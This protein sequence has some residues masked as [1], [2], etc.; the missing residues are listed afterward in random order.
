MNTPST[1]NLP[2]QIHTSSTEQPPPIPVWSEEAMQKAETQIPQQEISNRLTEQFQEIL[3]KD[4]QNKATT[5]QP[6]ALEKQNKT[7][8]SPTSKTIKST[9]QNVVSRLMDL[10]N[11][12]NV[13][14]ETSTTSNRSIIPER[15]TEKGIERARQIFEK[16]VN[17]NET[18]F[19]MTIAELKE[20]SDALQ[21][22]DDDREA[23]AS[24][25]GTDDLF[26]ERA[27]ISCTTE[28]LKLA[29]KSRKQL[30]N[31]AT[32]QQILGAYHPLQQKSAPQTLASPQFTQP[33]QELA[34]AVKKMNPE[35]LSTVGT[36]EQ[37][38]RENNSELMN[39]YFDTLDEN[40]ISILKQQRDEDGQNVFHKAVEEI[41]D[42]TAFE[43]IIQ[44]LGSELIS[45]TDSIG[46]TPLKY[47]IDK[48]N[49]ETVSVLLKHIDP[50]T[51]AKSNIEGESILDF[52]IE[53][54]LDSSQQLAKQGDTSTVK[55]ELE[56][57]IQNRS[58]LIQLVIEKMPENALHRSS[59]FKTI[60][61]LDLDDLTKT[62][63]MS[64][65]SKRLGINRTDS[66]EKELERIQTVNDPIILV[67]IE[68]P[69]ALNYLMGSQN[70]DEQEGREK[71]ALAI[72]EKSPKEFLQNTR[73]PIGNV[74]HLIADTGNWRLIDEVIN[75]QGL[76]CAGLLYQQ[77]H[78]NQTPIHMAVR[79][80]YREQEKYL[81]E[82]GT[83]LSK[84]L[85]DE[86]LEK[87]RQA[88]LNN[89][90]NTVRD[91]CQNNKKIPLARISTLM[92]KRLH[93]MKE[94][95][96]CIGKMV[97]IMGL[98]NYSTL[99]SADT[100]G[101]TCEELVLSMDQF[102]S[103]LKNNRISE[104]LEAIKEKKKSGY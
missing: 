7:P 54:L 58:A 80:A 18:S 71:V 103:A 9:D 59:L 29:L 60:A 94:S 57:N 99:Q 27:T 44:K 13:E 78:L 36:F 82:M 68:L 39:L 50:D 42:Q 16:A 2:P 30:Y 66:P 55:R 81:E 28:Q 90:W 32:A 40:S 63:L 1:T 21:F 53:D 35:E 4:E 75:R 52:A 98:T 46:N 83:L 56:E 64:A 6:T 74:L 91:L 77:T 88:V 102:Y 8:S 93:A 23:F 37:I 33:Q 61:Q 15:P 17:E 65:V 62:Q 24:D 26:D 11:L 92:D 84:G 85:E 5:R 100:E 48:G 67:N 22:T 47:A 95:N 79:R 73:W 96:A 87:C 69:K 31:S 12:E 45:E 25:L 86:E 70:E 49:K 41:E 10:E 19:K 101:L 20:L 97:R 14:I 51:L 89:K 104:A 34:S 38:A 72:L 43:T 76:D 3:R